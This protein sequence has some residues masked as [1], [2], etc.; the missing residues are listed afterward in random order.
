MRQ[1]DFLIIGAMKAGTTSVHKYLC[2]H[3]DLYLPPEK[4]APFFSDEECYARGWEAFFGDYF[5]DA[6]PGR[7]LGKVTPTYMMNPA[8]PE[9]IRSLCPDVRMIAIL[10][11]PIERAYSHYHMAVRIGKESR[12]FEDAAREQC[13]DACLKRAWAEADY[14]GNVIVFGEYGRILKR[15]YEL[16]PAEQL[17]VLYMDRLSAAPAQFMAEVLDF[18]GV[19]QIDMKNLGKRY[20][21][22]RTSGLM[23]LLAKVALNPRIS[24]LGRMVL[25][26]RVRRRLRFW[27]GLHRSGGS[28]TTD[29]SFTLSTTTRQR[30]EALYLRDAQLLEQLSGERP[31]WVDT[32]AAARGDT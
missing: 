14:W 8:V 2:E 10:R 13:Q 16:F 7:R 4:E 15:F 11:D 26:E 19:E 5:R 27:L 21:E 9:R 24:R 32:W 12:T 31:Y 30:L 25:P 28:S 22:S 17:H 1:L 20:H 23:P 29:S 3:P 6:P 18:I